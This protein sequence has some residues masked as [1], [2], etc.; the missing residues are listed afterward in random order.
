MLSLRDSGLR[1]HLS[2]IK[3]PVIDSLQHTSFVTDLSGKVF[4]SHYKAL[5]EL[6]PEAG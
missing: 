2:E 6:A 3:G 1:L 5:H 4:L